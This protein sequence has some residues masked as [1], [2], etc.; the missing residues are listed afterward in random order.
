MNDNT[1]LQSRAVSAMQANLA[2]P[3]VETLTCPLNRTYADHIAFV[4][5]ITDENL[6][7]Y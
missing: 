5:S 7:A 2:I 3:S 1:L 4:A 6:E